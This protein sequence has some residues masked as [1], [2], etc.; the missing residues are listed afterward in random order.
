VTPGL[1]EF[2]ADRRHYVPV[3]QTAEAGVI[4]VFLADILGIE[5]PLSFPLDYAGITR[6]TISRGGRRSARTVNEI[7]HVADLLD[8]VA[9]G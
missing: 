4:N 7:A 1:L 9:A 6:V 5:R 2:D 8:V 3:H